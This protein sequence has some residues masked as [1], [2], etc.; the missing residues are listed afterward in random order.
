MSQLSK[1]KHMLGLVV[2]LAVCF[3]AAGI[4]GTASID[5]GPFYAQLVRPDWAP[6]S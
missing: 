6:P 2:W 3:V 4:G 1:Q 5:A